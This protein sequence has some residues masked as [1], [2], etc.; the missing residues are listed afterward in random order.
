MAAALS[1]AT[2]DHKGVP[3]FAASSSFAEL[4]RCAPKNLFPRQRGD[5]TNWLAQG[6]IIFIAYLGATV[7]LR[8]VD[9]SCFSRKIVPAL[10]SLLCS[11][12]PVSFIEST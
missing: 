9:H 2:V 10:P 5:V 6:L 12:L 3:V 1:T 7:Q 4:V 8:P 11:Q